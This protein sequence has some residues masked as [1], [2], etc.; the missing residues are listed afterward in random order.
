MAA[1]TT[2]FEDRGHTAPWTTH[3]EGEA[4]LDALEAHAPNLRTSVVGSSEG[5]AGMRLVALTHPT[6]P[7]ARHV[8]FVAQQHGSELAGREAILSRLRDW[9]DNPTQ[10]ILDY[11]ATTTILVIPTAHPD[12]FTV[13]ENIN[14]VNLNRDHVGLTQAETRAVHAVIRDYQP[15]VVVDLH[16]G[17][18]I[19]EQAAIAEPVNQNADAEVLSLSV[20]LRAAVAD[21]ISTAGYTWEIYQGPSMMMRGAENLHNNAALD[22]R[23]S[24]LMETRRVYG[25]D[26]DAGTRHAIQVVAI[27]AVVAWDAEYRAAVSSTVSAARG[28]V[29]TRGADGAPF[30]VVTGIESSGMVLDPAPR[31]YYLPPGEHEASAVVRDLFRVTSTRAAE[32]WWVSLAQGTQPLI[33]YLFDQASEY[34]PA[35]GQREYTDTPPP[36]VAPRLRPS[37]RYRFR[38]GGQT[39]EVSRMRTSLAGDVRD[40][41]LT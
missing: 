1:P 26:T 13:R 18:N 17:A 20:D 11:L 6:T 14:A 40:V 28:R 38:Q 15:A 7:A 9:A 2:P 12:N 8:L 3:A 4:F 34:A 25:D 36:P 19:T 29:A 32:G 23:V 10:A 22:S 33:P 37:G 30:D 39:F 35:E 27:D 5:G 16:E 21:A 31:A 41:R 24:L